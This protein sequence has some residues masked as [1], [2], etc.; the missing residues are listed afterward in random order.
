MK[1]ATGFPVRRRLSLHHIIRGRRIKALAG[2]APLALCLA[3]P[4]LAAVETNPEPLDR[5]PEQTQ[6]LITGDAEEAPALPARPATPALGD[7]THVPPPLSPRVLIA[8]GALLA[9]IWLASR[10]PVWLL[11][12]V[13]SFRLWRVGQ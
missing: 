8:A 5:H 13:R 1:S 2:A 12:L 6:V 10:L 9:L 3:A 11:R 7:V 4:A